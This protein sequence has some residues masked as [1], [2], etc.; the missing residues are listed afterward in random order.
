VV[1]SIGGARQHLDRN[2][3]KRMLLVERDPPPSH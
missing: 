1:I 2:Q 3:I